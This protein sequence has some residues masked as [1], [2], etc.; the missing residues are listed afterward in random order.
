MAN[1]RDELIK[2]ALESGAQN[3]AVIDT[4]TIKFHEEFR[5][6]CERNVC[7]RYNTNWMGPPA[8]GHVKDLIEK[9]RK[10]PHGLLFQTVHQVKNSFDMNGMMEGGKK[11]EA[12]FRELLARLKTGHHF[13]E[14]LPLNAGCCR[15]CERCAYL[16]SQ[17]CRN[18]D[19]AVSSVEA[20]GMDV[21]AM[22]KEAGIPYY[23]GKNSISFV[24]LILFQSNDKD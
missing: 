15:T 6:A 18:P 13:K 19:K 8:I 1:T 17:P 10:Y 11:H 23:T 24:A 5:K 20:Y 16:D 3:A 22:E 14:M 4:S 7:R 9:V 2:L 21:A 12:I